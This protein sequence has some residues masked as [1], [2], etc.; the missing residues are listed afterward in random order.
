MWKHKTSELLEE[1]I[2]NFY[3]F[4]VRKY[5]LNK[6]PTVQTKKNRLANLT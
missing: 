1:N 6:T 5:I 2:E 3:N 4:G